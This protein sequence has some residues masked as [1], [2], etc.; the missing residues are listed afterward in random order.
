[1]NSD[2]VSLLGFEDDDKTTFPTSSRWIP[3]E[4]RYFLIKITQFPF[5]HR[6]QH[7]PSNGYLSRDR[8]SVAI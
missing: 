3:E 5:G 8:Y 4:E 6:H 1:M 7:H 2:P